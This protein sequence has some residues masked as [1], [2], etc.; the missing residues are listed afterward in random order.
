MTKEE[1]L[2]KHNLEEADYHNLKR[3]EE[4]R[5]SGVYNMNDYLNFITLNNI[6]GG[7]KIA[8]FIIN[9]NNNYKDFLRIIYTKKYCYNCNKLV[10]IKQSI[11][12]RKYKVKD[13]EFEVDI[14]I[15]RCIHCNEE[16]FIEE[17]EIEND[18]LVFNKYN[19]LEKEG[20]K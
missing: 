19:K 17:T 7:K 4:V 9:N 16:M 10:N 3:F 13:L 2:K 18:K 14:N 20:T 15:S 1:F 8:D 6:N 12:K 5:E 11:E